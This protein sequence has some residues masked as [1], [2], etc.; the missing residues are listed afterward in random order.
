MAH[1]RKTL[2]AMLGFVQNNVEHQDHD[3]MTFSGFMS[4]EEL[5]AY[6][7][8][9]CKQIKSVKRLNELVRWFN[10]VKEMAA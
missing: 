4:D 6:I 8:E 3:I 5:P 7:F 2:I 1:S 10:E 9:Q